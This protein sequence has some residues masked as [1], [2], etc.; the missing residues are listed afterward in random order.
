MDLEACQRLQACSPRSASPKSAVLL[1]SA[2]DKSPYHSPNGADTR[3]SRFLGSGRITGKPHLTTSCSEGSH[4]AAS[5]SGASGSIMLQPAQA[6][7]LSDQ[8]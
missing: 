1:M 4:L 7:S 5:D 3:L 2:H 8:R 6:L